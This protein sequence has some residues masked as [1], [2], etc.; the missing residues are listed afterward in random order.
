LYQDVRKSSN[1]IKIGK[2]KV[3]VTAAEQEIQNNFNKQYKAIMCQHK[4]E[5]DAALAL[6]G[7]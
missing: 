2:K 5:K 4:Q 6:L 7:L 1:E 3:V